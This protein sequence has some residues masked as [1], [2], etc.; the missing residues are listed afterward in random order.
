[1]D[2][3]RVAIH[4]PAASH[5]KHVR[6]IQDPSGYLAAIGSGLATPADGPEVLQR[7]REYSNL[8]LRARWRGERR[9]NDDNLTEWLATVWSMSGRQGK[10]RGAG[11]TDSGAVSARLRRVGADEISPW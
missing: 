5:L 4:G 3:T 9:P 2:P 10:R 7:F 6:A 11:P 1:M 8:V